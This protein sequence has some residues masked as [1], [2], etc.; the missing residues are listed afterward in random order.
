MLRR[1]CTP[2][3]CC[4][5]WCIHGVSSFCAPWCNA[6]TCQDPNCGACGPDH[7]CKSRDSS[8]TAAATNCANWCNMYTCTDSQ[9][10]DCDK[11]NC[12]AAAVKAQQKSPPSAPTPPPHPAVP[13]ARDLSQG[14]SDYWAYG[15]SIYTNAWSSDGHPTRLRIK[16]VSWFGMEGPICHPGGLWHR[17]LEDYAAFLRK[18][19]FNAVRI[20][21]AADAI[22]GLMDHP[23]LII[24]AE[25]K[26]AARGNNPDLYGLTY[27][28]ELARFVELLGNHGIL[29]LLD[30]H[31][32]EAGKWPDGGSVDANGEAQLRAAWQLV[33][34]Q[35][36]D[37]RAYWNVFAAGAA[38]SSRDG[39]GAQ[40]RRGW[41]TGIGTGRYIGGW[42]GAWTHT[43]ARLPYADLKNEP[44][45][46]YW[47]NPGLQTPAGTYPEPDRWDALARRLADM[48][49]ASCPRWLVLVQGVGHCR[50]SGGSEGG[51]CKFPSAPGNQNMEV[52]TWWGEV[53]PLLPTRH[54]LAASHT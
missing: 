28:D 3:L 33:A 9:C 29:V 48:L 43:R 30:M 40:C 23:C 7:G 53:R 34:Q 2:L 24:P 12:G 32:V 14:E 27:L 50:K 25:H 36:C 10:A 11:N 13:P 38:L 15:T 8:A 5:V 51:E 42:E 20:P 19:G 21:L 22:T 52:S 17:P 16:G 4:L 6:W 37:P 47:G 45:A 26:V 31:V 35:L 1:R 41:G 46:M 49:Q 39:V 18:H 54:R 44:Y